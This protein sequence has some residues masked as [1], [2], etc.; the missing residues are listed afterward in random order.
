MLNFSR[1]AEATIENDPYRWAIVDGLFSHHDAIALKENFPCD[2]FKTVTGNDGEKGYE[3][4]ARALIA[5]GEDRPAFAADL[6]ST[7]RDFAGDLL[8]E[9]YHSA[10][11]QLT[12]IDVSTL[13]IEANV[14]HYGRGAW[15]GPHVDLK[16]KIVTHIFYFNEAWD[17]SEGGSLS[18]LGSQ[19]LK[20]VRV[21]VPPIVG[22]SVVLV[23]SDNSWHAVPPVSKQSR[24]SRRSLALTFYAPG[25]VSTMWPPGD[26]MPLHTFDE[27]RN[28]SVGEPR[29]WSNVLR[30][31]WR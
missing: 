15:L 29:S 25:S 14:F 28:S 21:S 7:W 24:I 10:M 3:Y 19:D 5:M 1:I 27:T 30:R 23:R 13:T 12:G 26:R 22:N 17:R 16:E 31:V 18:I 2:H 8:S 20:D 9:P 11:T 4:E 6:D